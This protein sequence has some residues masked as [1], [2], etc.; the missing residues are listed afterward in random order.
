[1]LVPVAERGIGSFCGASF[2]FLAG[3]LFSAGFKLGLERGDAAG[4]PPVLGIAA[5]F[6][7]WMI[8]KGRGHYAAMFSCDNKMGG[9][10]LTSS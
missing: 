9:T 6:F 7:F 8:L 4:F 1:M 10:V 3:A 5:A 2:G